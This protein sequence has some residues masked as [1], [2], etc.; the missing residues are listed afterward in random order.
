MFLDY[1]FGSWYGLL[2]LNILFDIIEGLIYSFYYFDL[3][4]LTVKY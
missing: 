1:N 3:I 2:L 4:N